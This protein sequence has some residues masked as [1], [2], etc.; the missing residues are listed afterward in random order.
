MSFKITFLLFALVL[1]ELSIAREWKMR[2]N[3]S[4][5][6]HTNMSNKIDARKLETFGE[7]G[8]G[9]FESMREAAIIDEFDLNENS[10]KKYRRTRKFQRLEKNRLKNYAVNKLIDTQFFNENFSI[11]VEDKSDFYSQ[12]SRLNNDNFVND[13]G[14]FI[15][16]ISQHLKS[17][18]VEVCMQFT[19]KK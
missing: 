19:G 3:S 1:S 7:K 9:T 2:A 6:K 8:I 14:N 4:G 16:D 12:F 11:I 10:V 17:N 13:I 15:S 5:T 18:E